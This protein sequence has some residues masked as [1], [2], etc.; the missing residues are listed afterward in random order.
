M[1]ASSD[2][3]IAVRVSE[4]LAVNPEIR[5]FPSVVS[6][7][8]SAFQDETS[9]SRTFAKIIECDAALASRLLRMTNSPLYGLRREVRSIEHACSMLGKRSL[10]TLSLSLAGASMFSDGGPSLEERAELWRHSLGCASTARLLAEHVASVSPDDAF[11]AAIFH[12][13]GKLILYD[14]IPAEYKS[15]SKS[16]YGSELAEQEQQGLSIT[17]A[18]IG[19]R[20]AHAWNLAEEVKVAIGYHHF[21][22]QAPK[23]FEMA[24]LVGLADALSRNWGIGSTDASHLDVSKWT[25]SLDL[26][27]EIL[28]ALIDEARTTY[29]ETVRACA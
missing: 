16:T 13:V 23:H 19:L 15:L 1:A 8:L 2:Q 11:L 20:S 28:P 24:A 6:R 25:E 27:P 26:P 12:D 14:V 3:E 21:P 4:R 10:K 22:E 7:L 9:T 17:H 18:E 29:Q 5:P